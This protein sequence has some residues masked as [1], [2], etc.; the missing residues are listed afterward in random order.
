MEFRQTYQAFAAAQAVAAPEAWHLALVRAPFVA[1][2]Y[3]APADYAERPLCERVRLARFEPAETRYL[4]DDRPF[5]WR[6]TLPRPSA[7]GLRATELE[8]LELTGWMF[9]RA[10]GARATPLRLA[11]SSE[12][13]L[14]A[15]FAFAQRADSLAG[16][17]M[18]RRAVDRQDIVVID[19]LPGPPD[20]FS[21]VIFA[22][23]LDVDA[24]ERVEWARSNGVAT[25]APR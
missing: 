2:A 24:P 15:A 8:R 20:D 16:A 9:R 25:A 17:S 7:D 12:D 1:W 6:F 11:E 10:D 5:V 22:E 21:R 18:L 23:S 19:S 3:H 14:W 4:I 13:A